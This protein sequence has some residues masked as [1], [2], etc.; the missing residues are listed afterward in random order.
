M[1]DNEAGQSFISYISA[2]IL[3]SIQVS[4][5]NVHI[6]YQANQNNLQSTSAQMIFGL[7]LSS[8]KIMKQ[9]SVSTKGQV[10]KVVEIMGLEVY[11]NTSNGGSSFRDNVRDSQCLS[12]ASCE[13]NHF[14]PIL[15]PLNV[16]VSL[17]VN[18]PG[19]L[20]IDTPQWSVWAEITSLVGNMS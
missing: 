14:H 5:R 19:K 20:D 18:R 8:L 7:K 1:N 15:A 9:M 6:L 2:K 16:S 12:N 13:S 4:I 10:H 3:D 17:S 11:C